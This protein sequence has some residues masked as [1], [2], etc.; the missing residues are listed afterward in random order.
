MRRALQVLQRLLHLDLGLRRAEAL[1][2][3]S[4]FSQDKAVVDE[5]GLERS[6]HQMFSNQ[7]GKLKFNLSW[8]AWDF[9]SHGTWHSI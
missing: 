6:S 9:E 7:I 2:W 1:I 8:R 3:L 4:F 5:L